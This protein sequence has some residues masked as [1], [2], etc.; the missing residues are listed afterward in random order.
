[1][2]MHSKKLSAGSVGAPL[3]SLTLSTFSQSGAVNHATQRGKFL[4]S[5]LHALWLALLLCSLGQAHAAQAI[6][7]L[8]AWRGEVSATR[9]L[10]DNDAPHAYQQAQ[11]LQASLPDDATVIDRVRVLNLLARTEVYLALSESAEKHLQL[12]MDLALKKGDQVG[13]AEAQLNLA[14]AAINQGRV[15]ASMAA[16]TRSVELVEGLDRP[17]LL[18][19]ALLRMSMMYR[20]LNNLD[21]AV[22]IGMQTMEIA[23]R[24]KDP[25]ALT[26]ANQGLAIS[27]NLGA[28]YSLAG[29][30]Y[31][32]MRNN[33]RLVHSKLLEAQATAGMADVAA[34]LG[35][36]VEGER[37][38]REA[39]AMFRSVGNPFS[40]GS[41]LF[42]EA[43]LLH[44]QD[45]HTEAL[46]LLD[47]VVAIY[48]KYPNPIG[49]WSALNARSTNLQ[50]LGRAV[51]ARTD[52][53]R[54]YGLAKRLGFPIYL[55]ASARRLAELGVLDGDHP[56]AYQ[57]FVEAAKLADQAMLDQASARMLKLAERYATESKQREIDELTHRT[58]Q[59]DAELRQRALQQ[60]WLWTL[61]VG[62]ALVFAGGA[63]FLLRL[64]RSNRMLEAL[65]AQVQRSQSQL[66]ATFD[67]I[68]DLLFV[69]GL[70]GR[71][72]DIHPPHSDLLAAPVESL[73]GKT[74]SEVMS[75]ESADICLSALREA[76]EKGS[77]RGGQYELTLAQGS[78]W[79]ELSIAKKA[80]AAGEEP[81]FIGLCRDITERKQMERS[82]EE[83]RLLL[84]QLAARNEAA[85]E[86]E[87]KHLKREI[88]DELGQYL[89]ALRLGISVLGLEFGANNAPLQEKTDRLIQMVDATIK[90][91]RNVV[92]SL[93]PTALDLGIV[94]ALE[95]L[96]EE[97]SERTG[98]PCEL[99]LC[100]KSIHL[101]D[102]FATAIF[103]I[104]QE[105]LTNIAKHAHASQA[106]I[107][108]EQQEA[109]YLLEVRDNGCGFDPSLRKEK[110]FGLLSIQERV[111]MLGGSV[112]IASAPGRSTVIRVHIPIRNVVTNT[113]N[114]P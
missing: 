103:R 94:A 40:L 26:Y 84:R 21:S 28:S 99:H 89:S 73:I 70:D 74:I 87:R 92:S 6:S 32:Q 63:Y 18:G 67:A 19:E 24:N 79:F 11:R 62:S 39:I 91:A 82:L 68:P 102:T 64:R 29:E 66:Q 41:G 88:H 37:L 13:Q 109:D 108:F 25:L 69:T 44:R 27:F 53:E 110:S 38:M 86:D 16:T 49:L 90:V 56:R 46:S 77:S 81:R 100:E 2:Q 7:T 75:A 95:W 80:M 42:D 93:R 96:A 98:I 17:D 97:F 3:A 22:T 10:A 36:P 12:A 4:S 59:Q 55:N 114:E 23:K 47:E 85:R 71:Y 101:D 83:S 14:L 106:E 48:D 58:E 72:Y 111:L 51:A 43:D 35:N 54:A 78:F 8:D 15:D 76:N 5:V 65:N 1:M 34:R 107:T 30:H 52:A 113:L 9:T 61:L 45:R 33:A 60:R 105:S 104:V 50:A 20:R 112:E 57:L 31:L